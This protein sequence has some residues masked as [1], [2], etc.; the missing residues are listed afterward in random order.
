MAKKQSADAADKPA[1]GGTETKPEAKEGKPEAKEGKKPKA[2]KAPKPAADAAPAGGAAPAS[3][4]A[5]AAPA[6][7]KAPKVSSE[8][9]KK[10]KRAGV[11]PARGK[12]L[13]NHVKNTYDRIAKEGA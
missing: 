11:C 4:E 8:P 13:R 10:K 2:P 7:P 5:S 1:E 3:P 9:G 6:A 12:K